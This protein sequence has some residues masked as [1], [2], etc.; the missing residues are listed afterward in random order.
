MEVVSYN[1]RTNVTIYPNSPTMA[2]PLDWDEDEFPETVEN[3]RKRGGF[4]LIA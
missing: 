3:I 2:L 4:D 1:I